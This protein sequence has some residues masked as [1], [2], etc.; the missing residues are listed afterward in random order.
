[1]VGR[2]QGEALLIGDS[3][4]VQVLEVSG[5]RVK[6]GIKAPRDISVVRREIALTIVENLSAAGELPCEL[7]ATVLESITVP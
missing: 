6:L 7:L 5:N 3:I 2:R 4:E 1:M